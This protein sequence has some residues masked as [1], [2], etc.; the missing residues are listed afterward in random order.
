[1]FSKIKI[2]EYPF[3]SAI[4]NLPPDLQMEVFE[5]QSNDILKDK[6]EYINE[7]FNLFLQMPSI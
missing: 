6:C 2:F 1:M 4:G 5:I 7:N 3:G